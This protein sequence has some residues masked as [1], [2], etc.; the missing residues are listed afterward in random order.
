MKGF[1]KYLKEKPYE[2]NTLFAFGWTKWDAHY[3]LISHLMKSTG[4]KWHEEKKQNPQRYKSNCVFL[5][6]FSAYPKVNLGI[7]GKK[8]Y[9][10]NPILEFDDSETYALSQELGAPVIVDFCKELYGNIFDQDRRNLSTYLKLYSSNQNLLKASSN[11]YM[12]NYRTFIKFLKDSEIVPPVEELDGV[13]HDAY[14]SNF[15]AIYELL[16]H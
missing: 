3:T 5:A 8:I 4:L 12:Y 10:I 16:K 2:D 15:D 7:P 14:D 9:R 11:A 6:S 13:M 1:H